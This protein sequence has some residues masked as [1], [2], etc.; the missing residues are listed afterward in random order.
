MI[1]LQFLVNGLLLGG[2]YAC[3]A[4]GF[5]LVWGVLHIINILH[6]AFIVLGAYIAFYSYT[7]LGIHPFVSVISAGLIL[8]VIGYVMQATLINRVV[9][10]S[11]LITLT[12]TFGLELILNNAMLL[13][14]TADFRKVVLQNPLG[15]ASFGG[16]FVPLDRLAAMVLSLLVIAA[17]GITLKMTRMGR[18]IVAVR[19]DREAASLMGVNVARTYALTFAI[20]AMMAG[21]AGSLMSVIF[22]V[23]PLTGHLFLGKAFVICVLGGIGSVA[24]AVIGGLAL[25]LIESF[26]GLVFGPENALILSFVLLLV[27]L[28]VRPQGIM[29]KKEH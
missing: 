11:V 17:V 4:A 20:G 6:G 25:G 26:G 10:K 5:S 7:L 21:A 27:L 13:A 1:Y 14:F 2:L 9:T 23:S 3:I 16:V 28:V 29:G 18:A 12:L 15:N 8:G 24:G 22:P 19:T